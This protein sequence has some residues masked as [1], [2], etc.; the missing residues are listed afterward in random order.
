MRQAEGVKFLRWAMPRLGLDWPGFEHCHRQVCKRLKRRIGELG[1]S[2]FAAYRNYTLDHDTEW[3]VIDTCCRVTVSRFYRDKDVFDELASEVV[4]RLAAEAKARGRSVVRAW[5]AGC[6]AGEEPFSLGLI[7]RFKVEPRFPRL[8]LEIVATDADDNQ[9][10]RARVGCY[11]PSSLR[12]LPAAW[13]KGAFVTSGPLRCLRPK[14]R[15]GIEF[16]RQDVR[17]N[18]P[19]GPFDLILCR[20][21]AFTYF[22]ESQQREV[23]AMIV[24]KLTPGGFLV[25]GRRERLPDEKG[26][27]SDWAP[28]LRIFTKASAAQLRA[29]A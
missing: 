12:E 11:R 15:A 21:L 9:L 14:F 10:A 5:S 27:L 2:G 4:P 17:A 20:N 3:E 28:D 6:G 23:L 13:A 19:K 22:D 26:G 8:S 7:W 24:R 1:L 29:V 16:E 25:I 18:A